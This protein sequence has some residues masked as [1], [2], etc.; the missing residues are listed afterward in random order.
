MI[1]GIRVRRVEYTPGYLAD[2]WCDRGQ[3]LLVIVGELE[4]RTRG[5]PQIRS[6]RG[7]EL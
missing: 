3:I 2:H 5:W 4:K 6:I 1:G 7:H